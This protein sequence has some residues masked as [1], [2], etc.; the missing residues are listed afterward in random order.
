MRVG[1]QAILGLDSIVAGGQDAIALDAVGRLG[2]DAWTAAE[3]DD[4]AGVVGRHGRLGLDTRL[5]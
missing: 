3:P 2:F 4:E 5:A 1:S